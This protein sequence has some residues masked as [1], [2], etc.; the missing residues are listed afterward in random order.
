MNM[1]IIII[2]KVTQKRGD[3]HGGGRRTE[4]NCLP[5]TDLHLN[6]PRHSTETWPTACPVP[7]PS[8]HR[9]II[10]PETKQPT[11]LTHNAVH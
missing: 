4:L 5:F 1:T 6:F 8:S 2:I 3:R 7:V 9:A 10:Q 11:G